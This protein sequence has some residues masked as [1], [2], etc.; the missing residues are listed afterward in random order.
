MGQYRKTRSEVC[1]KIMKY[2]VNIQT[3]MR[4]HLEL[5]RLEWAGLSCRTIDQEHRGNFLSFFLF[6]FLSFFPSFFFIFSFLLSFFLSF[7]VWPLSDLCL[8]IYSKCRGLLLH[9]ITL[10]DTH[11]HTHTHT[12]AHSDAPHSL[13]LLCTSEQP[14]SKTSTQQH[15][16]LTTNMHVPGGIRTRSPSKGAAAD[17]RLRRKILERKIH[18]SLPVGNPK[19]RWIDS[20]TRD[21]RQM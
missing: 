21:T 10:S 20:V 3:D 8:S 13:G 11:T 12:H 15:T 16:T 2:V 9:L 7:S 19:D 14:D 5:R 17:R 6:F 4:T 18:G 1:G